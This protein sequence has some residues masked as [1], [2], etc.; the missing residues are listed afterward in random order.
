MP[1]KSEVVGRAVGKAAPTGAWI[2]D[3]ES[4][5]AASSIPANP[6]S[7]APISALRG[8]GGIAVGGPS[9]W[10]PACPEAPGR[11]PPLAVSAER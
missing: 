7:E 11:R 6:W 5:A 4:Y 3:I 8:R 2:D 10:S 1:A 9:G